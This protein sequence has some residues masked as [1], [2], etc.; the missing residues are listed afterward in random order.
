MLRDVKAA[1][2]M[3][4]CLAELLRLA[5]DTTSQQKVS[6]GQEVDFLR[7]YLDIQK[8]RFGDR[9]DLKIA[10]DPTTLGAAVPNMILQPIVEN[11]IEHAVEA[12][13]DTGR[14]EFESVRDESWLVLSVSDNGSALKNSPTNGG[15]NGL[16]WVIAGKACAS[17]MANSNELIWS[18]TRW[19]E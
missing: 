19:T 9:L 5:L 8:I 6:L 13:E 2:A 15:W 1:N 3:I 7:K 16:A 18:E 11:A 10:I 12:R 17:F 4:A 14:I